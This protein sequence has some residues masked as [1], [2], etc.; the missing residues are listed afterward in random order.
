MHPDSA[1]LI[2][3]F[4]APPSDYGPVVM[5]F[6]NDIIDEDGISFQM[7]KFREQNLTNVF[8]HPAAGFAV[9]YLSD[10]Y[11]ELICHTVREAKRLGMYFW[12]YDEYRYPSGSAGGIL[13]R[14]FP[15]Y[16]QKEIRVEDRTLWPHDRVTITRPGQLLSAQIVLTK[17]DRNEVIDVTDQCI[18]TH[19]GEYTEVNYWHKGASIPTRVLFFFSEVN[20]AYLPSGM[21]RSD[22]EPVPGYAD[23]LSYEAVGK[24]IELTHERYKQHIGNEFGKTVRG[25]FTD[26]PTTLRHFDGTVATC[27]WNDVFDEE[28]QKDHGYSII[29]WLYLFWN[30][31]PKR[32]QEHKAIHDCRETIKRLYFTNFLKQY[33]QWCTDNNLILTGHFGGEEE[34]MAHVTQCD[35]LEA[36]T[37]LHLPG[38]D[39]IVSS[40]SIDQK[41]FNIAAKMPASAAKFIGS[42]RVLC[43]TFSGSGWYMRF[44]DMKR[45]ANRLMLLGVNWI[46]YMGAYYTIGGTAKNY[47]F[48]YAPSHGYMNPY[49]PFYH[50]LGEHIA[51]FSALS[52]KTVPDASVLLFLPVEQA[53]QDRY[54]QQ[55]DRLDEHAQFEGLFNG[56]LLDTVNA[57]V[58]EGIGFELFSE[59]LTDNI[60]VFDGYLEA[61]G[62]RYD[63]VI[64]PV[65]RFVNARTR[66]LIAEL[67][68]HN[69]KMIFL[70]A[71]PEVE[72]DSGE[73]F[74][75]GFRMLSCNSAMDL[76]RDGSAWLITPRV[77]PINMAIHRTALQTVIGTRYLNFRADEGVFITKRSSEH[78]DVYFLCNDN[79]E[80]AAAAFDALP[81]MR[82][83]NTATGGEACYIVEN[84]RVSL[85]LE[86]CDMLAILCDKQGG[87]LPVTTA[88]SFTERI[89]IV[90]EGPYDFTPADGNYLP[91]DYEMQDPGTGLWDPCRFL[92]FSDRIYLAA[93][94]PYR[95]RSR[96]RIDHLPQSVT[97]N[98]E[99]TRVTQL[100]VNGR[101]LPLVVNVRRW[102][103]DDHTSEIG[104]LL[105]EGEN[106]IEIEGTANPMPILDRPPYV[107]LAG[108]F[109]VDSRNHLVEPNHKLSAGGWEQAGYPYFCGTGIYKARFTAEENYR[110]ASVNLHTKDIAQ[111][112][113]N[114]VYAGDKLW[115]SEETDITDLL[116]PGENELEVRVTPTRANMFAA[117]WYPHAPHLSMTR[118]E[119]GILEP[120]EI[121]YER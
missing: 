91:L 43:E 113:I 62:H 25:V 100:T 55:R 71:L 21:L 86:A 16:R 31:E 59:A 88:P 106:I 48:G 74:D 117:E 27:A 102:S 70:Y 77:H 49:F 19:H 90:L 79:K 17:D 83:L 76:S 89:S 6:W 97:I 119:N 5:W 111:V 81:G 32:A 52:A 11:M 82:I 68:A 109:G 94:A 51:A 63:T 80:P 73:A 45:I 105:H 28:F 35:M 18:Q 98:A 85:T 23:M 3:S 34:I 96:V 47:P 87:N 29:P 26:E 92:Y 44:S 24:F 66:T 115:L 93:G 50:K 65:M 67:K 37:L 58:A 61:Y 13:C 12:I 120:M 14:D 53:R 42:D 64:F 114:G 108:D 75:T 54:K 110:K 36:L 38:M 104:H 116:Q 57:L 46:Q 4:Q 22:F 9:D 84:G 7:E 8:V 95:I 121:C 20:L 2:Q 72:V 101:P 78:T 99:L 56:C 39:T 33:S 69:V 15:Q 60:T 10:R 118:T 30:I 40:Q 103:T 41:Q 107:Y 112:Y 1:N